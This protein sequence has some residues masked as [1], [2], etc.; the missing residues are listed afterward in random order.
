MLVLLIIKSTIKQ[1]KAVTSSYVF[2]VIHGLMYDQIKHSLFLMVLDRSPFGAELT[3]ANNT[4]YRTRA[5]DPVELPCGISS[6]S[7]NAR[8]S[9]LKNGVEIENLIQKTYDNSLLIESATVT[10]SGH[11]ICRIDD[12][13]GSRLTSH[14]TLDVDGKV[15][16]KS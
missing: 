13:F 16:N 6:V 3:I 10:D 12:E 15:V 5:G 1:D 2:E 4:E 8:I 14:M 7:I 9:W 11:Y